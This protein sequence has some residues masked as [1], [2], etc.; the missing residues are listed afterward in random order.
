LNT[1]HLRIV[2]FGTAEFGIPSLELLVENNYTISGIVTVPD[3]P[4]GRGQKMHI[5]P[6]KE[7]AQKNNLLLLQ[8]ENLKDA[9]FQNTLRNLKADLF[10]V[11]AFRILPE[12]VWK[13]PPLGT[14]N[15]HASL[16]PQYRGAAPINRAIMN[17]EKETGITTFFLDEHT[18]TGRIIYTEKIEISSAETA[19][20]LHDRLKVIGG[21][22][23]VKT[24]RAIESGNI[25]TS[26]QTTLEK[27]FTLLHK[28]PKIKKED[29]R[30]SWNS[31]AEA[32]YNFI[33]GL[34]PVP[35]AYTELISPEGNIHYFKIF[36]SE[37]ETIGE[38]DI[39]AGRIDTDSRS[40]LK[41]AAED[42]FISISEIQQKGR[43]RLGIRE[44]LRGFRIDESW[45]VR[46]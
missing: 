27:T 44:F 8:P 6:V 25:N 12:A 13:M 10:I 7:F 11:I 32:I 17:G 29:C 24:V 14:F 18:D 31:K 3:R 15:L 34:S 39:P 9:D 2:F 38:M 43:R 40:Y 5:S 41:I 21:E 35:A 36:R 42:G 22:L 1:S 45:E 37:A 33:R 30:I 46:Q 23:V 16:L 28:A 4:A 26:E 20:E 19:G